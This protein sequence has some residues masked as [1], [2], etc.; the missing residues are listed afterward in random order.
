MAQTLD[1]PLELDQGLSRD[2][3][4]APPLPAPSVP[5]ITPFSFASAPT[6]PAASPVP[7]VSPM[8]ADRIAP[9]IAPRRRFRLS[10][11]ESA[12]I[13]LIFSGTVV[14]IYRLLWAIRP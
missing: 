11:H 10:W 13:L 12:V 2:S 9:R 5:D 7:A 6:V 4:L 14:C 1:D 3:S 8:P